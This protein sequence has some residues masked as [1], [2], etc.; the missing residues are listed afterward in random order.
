MQGRGAALPAPALRIGIFVVLRR[1][2]EIDAR[3]QPFQESGADDPERDMR[4]LQRIAR[5]GHATGPDRAEAKAAL[6]VQR[7]TT[8]TDEILI[9]WKFVPAVFA[10]AHSG[11]LHWPA[12]SRAAH[13]ALARRCCPRPARTIRCVRLARDRALNDVAQFQYSWPGAH[14]IRRVNQYRNRRKIGAPFHGNPKCRNG[15]VV[16]QGV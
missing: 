9:Q 16:C 1:V 2:R 15:P 13:P 12:R 8:E 5:S 6:S 7:A 10:D 11:P 4:R 14:K 3:G